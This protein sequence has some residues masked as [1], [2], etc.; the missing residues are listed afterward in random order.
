MS[1][2]SQ[3]LELHSQL[4]IRAVSSMQS[5]LPP[6]LLKQGIARLSMKHFLPL[7]QCCSLP[8]P[9]TF[10]LMQKAEKLLR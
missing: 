6:L 3:L 8:S 2:T 9:K 7:L 10:Y 4:Q 5:N 1:I